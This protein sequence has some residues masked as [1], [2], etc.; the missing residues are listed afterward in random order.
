MQSG[1]GSL[2][3][4]PY[5]T[6]RS[7][8]DPRATLLAFCQSAYEAATQ[9]G[10][11]KSTLRRH[12]DRGADHVT[13]RGAFPAP[14][15]MALTS[16]DLAVTWLRAG[17]GASL[18][19]SNAAKVKTALLYVGIEGLLATTCPVPSEGTTARNVA[20]AHRWKRPLRLASWLCIALATALSATSALSYAR[21][22]E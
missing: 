13:W 4:L 7:S 12:L 9:L 8:R 10:V 11:S 19:P 2:A 5:E 6:V 3:I 22:R 14:L 1:G 21:R 18:K 15:G 16:R 17:R 20:P